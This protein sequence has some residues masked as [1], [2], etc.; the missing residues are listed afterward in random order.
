MK[1]VVKREIIKWLDA[2]IA[3]PMGEP[4]QSIVKKG[5][6]TVVANEKKE[7]IPA[8][9][10]TDWR[11]CMDYRKLNKPTKM[12]HFPLQLTDQ[13]L[14]MLASKEFS[15]F[16]DSYSAITKLHDGNFYMPL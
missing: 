3:Y 9:T 6:V 12:D 16:F 5:G 15:Y 14:D 8:R 4:V 10:V 1:K 7:L 13:M 2:G 11:I